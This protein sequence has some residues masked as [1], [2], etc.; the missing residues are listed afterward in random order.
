MKKTMPGKTPAPL[1]AYRRA[2]GQYQDRQAQFRRNKTGDIDI[3]AKLAALHTSSVRREARNKISPPVVSEAEAAARNHWRGERNR[4]GHGALALTCK[5]LSWVVPTAILIH[6]ASQAKAASA[7]AHDATERFGV[8]ESYPA[9]PVVGSTAQP[10]FLDSSFVPKVKAEKRSSFFYPKLCVSAFDKVRAETSMTSLAALRDNTPPVDEKSASKMP[11]IGRAFRVFIS[12]DDIRFNKL[13]AG[14]FGP[15]D[16]PLNNG[17][18]SS[19]KPIYDYPC[20]RTKFS[21]D[22]VEILNSA[23][24]KTDVALA[25]SFDSIIPLACLLAAEQNSRA[26]FAADDMS[27]IDPIVTPFFHNYLANEMVYATMAGLKVVR[28]VNP[29][30]FAEVFSLRD[31]ADRTLLMLALDLGKLS[32]AERLLNLIRHSEIPLD[33]QRHIILAKGCFGRT[34][35]HLAARFGL[36]ELLTS[37]YEI[38]PELKWEKDESGKTPEDLFATHTRKSLLKMLARSSTDGRRSKDAF[39]NAYY[40][41]HSVPHAPALFE[42]RIMSA[43]GLRPVKV[44]STFYPLPPGK[45]QILACKANSEIIRKL[46][47]AEMSEVVAEA[48]LEGLFTLDEFQEFLQELVKLDS[49]KKPLGSMSLV[50]SLMETVYQA[51]EQKKESDQPRVSAPGL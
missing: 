41:Q 2:I 40:G 24:P 49:V 47:N 22:F 38:A 39:A 29:S 44:R 32:I 10:Q 35:A 4:R 26:F 8:V 17:L 33:Q 11:K 3:L 45:Q 25:G 18:L 37:M 51:K 16:K 50:D 14:S 28:E 21:G 12:D 5:S 43:L 31:S 36:R 42:P 27:H 6:L 13:L 19:G 34:A 9:T 7:K 48:I 23:Y 46:S 20:K 15:D 1:Q 30:L